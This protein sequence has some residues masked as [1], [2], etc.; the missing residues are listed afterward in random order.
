MSARNRTPSQIIGYGLYLYFLGLSFR[1]AAKALSFLH[2]IK[3]SHVSIWNWIQKYKPT[4]K[5]NE[6]K[7][8]NEY[9]ID[10]TAVKVGSELIWLWVIIE[11]IDK[12][13]LSINISKERNMFVVE[14]FIS[15][16]IKE[17]GT[18]P[19][20]TDG[21]TWYPQACKFLKLNHHIHSSFE[22]SI[23]ER[24]MQ[25]IKDRIE[26]FDDY[27]PCKKNKCKLNHVKQW[28]NLFIVQHNKEITS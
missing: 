10:E 22:K 25:Y 21:G 18:H 4:K 13:I 15:N 17:Y 3:I 1:N 2:L 12:E 24:A 28:L 19:V 20:S 7:K 9:I 5:F 11:P 27:F 26:N 14:R 8:I 16:I 23:I 6:K